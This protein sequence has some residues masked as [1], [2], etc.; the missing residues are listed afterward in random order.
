MNVKNRVLGKIK[1]LVDLVLSALNSMVA[2]W[3]HGLSCGGIIFIGIASAIGQENDPG[4]RPQIGAQV[5]IEPGQQEKEIQRWFE[6]LA[7]HGMTI[8]RIRMDETHM[9]IPS[10]K[11]D[12]SLYDIAFK[13]A[14]QHNIKI[15]ATLFPANT[16]EGVGGFKFPSSSDHQAAIQNYIENIV[17]H[18]KD[19]PALYAWVL[20]NE[21]GIGGGIPRGDHTEKAWRQWIEEHPMPAREGYILEDY[22]QEQFLRDHTTA[23]LQWIAGEVH[24]YDPGRHLHVN[25][26]MLFDNLPEYDFIAWRGFLTSFGSSMHPS[27]HFGYFQR[28]QYPIAI[29]ANNDIV[30]SGAGDHPFWVTELQGGNNSYSGYHPITPS[31][32][33]IGQWLWSG[34]GSGAQGIIFW[35]LNPRAA[36]VEA[37]E[38]SLLDFIDEPTDRLKEAGKI[39]QVIRQPSW[40]SAHPLVSDVH[41]LYSVDAMHLQNRREI[42]SGHIRHYHEGRMKGATVKSPLAFYET[43]LEYG[44]SSHFTDMDHFD[45]KQKGEQGH[46]VILANQVVIPRHHWQGIIDFVAAG[47]KLL[48]TGLTA[49]FDEFGL[50]VMNSDFP[51]KAAFGGKVKEFRVKEDHFPL[52][53]YKTLTLPAHWLSGTLAVEGG[54]PIGQEAGNTTAIRNKYGKGEVIWIPSLVGLGAWRGDNTPLARL[55][56][57]EVIKKDN[58]IHF[59]K[60]HPGVTMKV[61]QTGQDFITIVTNKN[62]TMEQIELKLAGNYTPAL[63]YRLMDSTIKGRKLEIAADDCLV[64]KWTKN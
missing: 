42:R 20:Q 54:T 47:G 14:E 28:D 27:W 2:A 31:R 36:G 45:W 8:C 48:V 55:L 29:A 61:M 50:N 24:R 23:Y 44:I 15:F 9:R 35:T 33:E 1:Q 40:P 37:G 16:G 10:G 3:V 53:V 25:S 17:Q 52:T 12:F 21:P 51:F 26:H 60:H 63:I 32:S 43:L 49:H 11:W 30:R 22:K 34:I 7:D 39:A 46:T 13:A 56:K 62:E 57:A 4:T 6:I 38:W 5:Y 18:F 59:E 19:H 58:V 41:I 64:V